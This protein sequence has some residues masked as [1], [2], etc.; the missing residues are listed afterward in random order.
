MERYKRNDVVVSINESINVTS[1]GEKTQLYQGT[2]L[3]VFDQLSEIVWFMSSR[4]IKHPIFTS[5]DNIRHATP[6]EKFLYEK[7]LKKGGEKIMM[8]IKTEPNESEK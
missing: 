5:I 6:A 7:H 8:P 3:T 4:N 1:R 2:I